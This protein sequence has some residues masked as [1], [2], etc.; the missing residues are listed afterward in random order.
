MDTEWKA[1]GLVLALRSNLNQWKHT[2]TL[3]L[4]NKTGGK[5]G[6]GREQSEGATAVRVDRGSE[7]FA[8]H[9]EG[10]LNDF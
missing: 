2:I 10:E 4:Y 7:R 9:R 6:G 8:G 5:A 3:L 1:L